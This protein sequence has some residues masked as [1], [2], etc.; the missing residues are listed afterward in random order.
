MSSLKIHV[1]GDSSVLIAFAAVDRLEI[2]ARVFPCIWVPPEVQREVR[3]ADLPPNGR[4]REALVQ[5]IF[6]RPVELSAEAE[7]LAGRY[8]A[9][10]DRGEAEAI[11]VAK[12]MDRPVLIDDLPAR[13]WAR[14]E[15]VDYLGSLRVLSLGKEAGVIL[16]VRPV[17][18]A[19]RQEGRFFSRTLLDKFFR[20]EGE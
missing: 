3:A 18:E 7:Q 6:L 4:L 11:A 9:V 12:C 5:G 13:R 19:M 15:G 1:V 2:L 17:A 20:M 16:S 10:V 8:E 14:A